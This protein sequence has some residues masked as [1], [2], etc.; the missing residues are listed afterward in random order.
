[1][2]SRQDGMRTDT[3]GTMRTGISE[4]TITGTIA[5]GTTLGTTAAS[6]VRGTME[7]ST[8]LGIMGDITTHGTMGDGM[9]LGTMDSATVDGTIRS[10]V[11]CIRITADG[12]EDG[13]LTTIITTMSHILRQEQFST[14]KYT[15]VPALRH[16]ATAFSQEEV[17][18]DHHQGT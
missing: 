2:T 4:D 7:V 14:E 3:D 6:T 15:E 13:I 1:M 18:Q 10:M 11:T 17:H 9:T 16:Q 8:A 12:M 5:D